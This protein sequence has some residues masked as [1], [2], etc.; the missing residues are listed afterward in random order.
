GLGLSISKQVIET[1]G[2]TI[3]AENRKSNNGKILGARFI[4]WLPAEN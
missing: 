3:W 4:F 1:H 2:G